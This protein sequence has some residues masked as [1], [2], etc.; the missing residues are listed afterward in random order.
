VWHASLSSCPGRDRFFGKV[1]WRNDAG[2]PIRSPGVVKPDLSPARFRALVARAFAGVPPELH[3]LS[4]GEESRAS[5]FRSGGRQYVARVGFSFEGFDKEF[6]VSERWG[7]IGVPIPRVL[8]VEEVDGYA[9][10]V[11]ERLPGR[12]LQDTEASL[13]P[14]LVGPTADALGKIHRADLSGTTGFGHFDAEGHGTDESWRGWLLGLPG[15]PAGGFGGGLLREVRRRYLDLVRHC[16]EE[17]CLLHGDFGSNNVLTD[18]AK[19]TGVLDW[20]CALF[21][22]PLFDVANFYFWRPWLRCMEAQAGYYERLPGKPERHRER[23]LCYGLRI[24]LDEIHANLRHGDEGMARW[25]LRR[26]VQMT[27]G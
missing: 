13:L 5:W 10:C 17:R 3:P 12:T 8:A 14:R 7:R 20:D 24:G 21:G 18:S 9:V 15:E 23:V 22:D 16:P 2:Y 26:C 4:E 25:A 11:S 6:F 19:I 1:S 27:E